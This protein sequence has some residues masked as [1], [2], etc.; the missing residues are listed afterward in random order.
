[1]GEFRMPSLGADM[2][3]GTLVEWAVDVGDQVSKGDIIASVET[4]KS[5]IEV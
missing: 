1:M 3:E 2:E 4:D 5:T